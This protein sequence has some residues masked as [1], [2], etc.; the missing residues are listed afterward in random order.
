M[1]IKKVILAG[2]GTGGHIYPALAIASE[3]KRLYS[4]VKI[5]FVGTEMGLEKTLIPKAGY[6][7]RII[8]VKGFRRKLSLDTLSSI[9]QMILG[10]I[11]S[12]TIL[13]R[14]K[15]DLVIGTGGYVSGP[16]I[17]FASLLHIP[18]IIHEQNVIPG[19]TNRIL[20]RFVNKVAISFSESEKYL[21]KAKTI[22]TGNPVRKEIAG[23]DR[24]K[25]LKD[26]G[27]NA[28]LPVVLSFGGSQGAKRLNEAMAEVVRKISNNPKFQLIHVTG[29]KQYD[30]FIHLLENKGID[31]SHTGNIIIRPYI[32]DMQKAYAAA[33]LVISRAGAISI[34]EITLC[35]K[36]AILIPLPNAA[37]HHQDF[38]AKI[39]QD[40]GAA[41]ILRDQELSGEILFDAIINIVLDKKRLREMGKASRGLAKPDALDS[42]M[43]IIK[44]LVG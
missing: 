23:G 24:L 35:G 19:V 5:V 4:D 34:S 14:E 42:I 22:L 16:I 30:S 26:F 2:G 17:F 6:P 15:P 20:S 40:N 25:A 12:L 10:G 38:N 7:L 33:D 39:L 36:P 28:N 21:P 41:I 43:E 3:I 29:Q 31:L 44:K 18:T 8:R 11:D 37:G 1:P 13:K 32:Y 9:K 27:L